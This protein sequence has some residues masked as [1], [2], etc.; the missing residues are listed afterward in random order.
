ME[1]SVSPSG[2]VSVM[3]GPTSAVPPT[4]E[5]ADTWQQGQACPA[6]LGYWAE[7][8]TGGSWLR[9]WASC[10]LWGEGRQEGGP[11]GTARGSGVREGGREGPSLSP[12]V[13]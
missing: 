6:A 3:R 11:L 7:A 12:P 2:Q 9:A 5:P 8:R 4:G 10:G 1:L 13:V